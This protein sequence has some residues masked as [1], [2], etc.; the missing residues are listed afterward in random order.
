MS[1]EGYGEEEGV[2]WLLSD[3][4]AAWILVK[5]NEM[6]EAITHDDRSGL[7]QEISKL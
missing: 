3:E 7:V 1:E 5:V 4:G 6:V 2:M